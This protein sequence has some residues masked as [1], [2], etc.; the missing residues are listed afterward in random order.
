MQEGYQL[1]GITLWIKT[2]EGQTKFQHLLVLRTKTNTGKQNDLEKN[3]CKLT[4]FKQHRDGYGLKGWVSGKTSFRK[5]WFDAALTASWLLFPQRIW[6]KMRP[7]NILLILFKGFIHL[8]LSIEQA[9]PL[10]N[11]TC[12]ENFPD[13]PVAQLHIWVLTHFGKSQASVICRDQK[14]LGPVFHSAAVCLLWRREM[15]RVRH[16]VDLTSFLSFLPHRRTLSHTFPSHSSDLS[17]C[18]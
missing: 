16:S 10:T 7:I 18:L 17:L 4:D 9:S 12:T 11:E 14:V 8:S 2:T 1:A 15:L 13:F 6:W 3:A 5:S